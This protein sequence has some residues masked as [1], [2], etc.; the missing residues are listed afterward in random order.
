M[1]ASGIAVLGP[2]VMNQRLP[3][4]TIAWLVRHQSGGDPD[5]CLRRAVETG[6]VDLVKELLFGR[7]GTDATAG[8]A[9]GKAA[10]VEVSTTDTVKAHPTTDLL[11]LCG[12]DNPHG[13]AVA[14]VS[15]EDVVEGIV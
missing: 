10:D 2:E 11:M 4:K 5:V 12:D 15:M 6:M 3:P 8:H 14:N 7:A 9:E 1:I 13:V